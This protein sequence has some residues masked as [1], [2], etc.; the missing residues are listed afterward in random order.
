M[1]HTPPDLEWDHL[2][3]FEAVAR[4]GSQTAAAH[5]LGISLSSVSRHIARLE[6][7]AGTP[8]LSRGP[9]AA[10][11]DSGLALREAVQPMLRAALAAR[12]A[13]DTSAALSGEVVITSVGEL[14]RWRLADKV[15]VL[16]ERHPELRLRLLTSNQVVN[17]AT[18]EA[19]IALRMARPER[20]ELIA[21]R[22][23]LVSY[24]LCI[25]AALPRTP[26]TPWLSLTGSLAQLPEQRYIERCFA[27]RTPRLMVENTEALG[28]LVEA[29]L[30]AAILPRSLIGRLRDVVEITPQELG[31][32][33]AE[34]LPERSLWLV[35]HPTRQH[36]PRVRAV[37]HW[38]LEIF[39]PG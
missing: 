36:I 23:S 33:A 13:L 1:Q 18:G 14:V 25:H 38:L 11:T 2:R 30:G 7:Q 24:A 22:L 16:V 12:S 27:D 28:M 5:A 39:D 29:G 4:L 19:D 3:T 35:V 20:G 15:K 31:A 8:L 34:P 37:I 10:L 9:D 26:Q 17:L 32:R 21:R 6:A